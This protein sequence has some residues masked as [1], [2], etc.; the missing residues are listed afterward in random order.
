[1][2]DRTSWSGQHRTDVASLGDDIFAKALHIK[3]IQS[4]AS[5]VL[6]SRLAFRCVGTSARC[7][8]AQH[9]VITD[10]PRT[11]LRTF[12]LEAS[13][14]RPVIAATLHDCLGPAALVARLS[15]HL[16]ENLLR[17]AIP[18]VGE[19]I[20]PVGEAIP[21]VGEAIP[22]VGKA[23][24]QVGKVIPQVDNVIPQVGKAFP[25]RGS[26]RGSAGRG[27]RRQF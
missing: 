7:L 17:R 10:R 1:M 14:K 12:S 22:P 9:S 19:A 13:P 2:Q 26:G 18:P 21:P 15:L 23:I 5:G 27:S 20:P 25:R 3:R 6:S 8:S 16:L 24:P 11:Q 4:L